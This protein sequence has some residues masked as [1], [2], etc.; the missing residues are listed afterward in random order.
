MVKGSLGRSVLLACK[1]MDQD[2]LRVGGE[3]E[4]LGHWS[5]HCV[6]RV[7]LVGDASVHLGNSLVPRPH[8][9][10]RRRVW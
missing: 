7:P 10:M 5:G 2:L 3:K 8:P 1:E 4:L 6:K 9:L